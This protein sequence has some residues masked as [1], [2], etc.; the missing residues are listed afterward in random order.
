MMSHMQK[1]VVAAVLVLCGSAVVQGA[2]AA[3]AAR[4]EQT[5]ADPYLIVDCV[6]REV[7]GHIK[8]YRAK[9]TGAEVDEHIDEFF[10]LMDSTLVKAIDF[11]WIALNVMGQYRKTATAEQRR[12]FADAFH[13]GL[14]ETYGRGLLSYSNEKIVLVPASEP[15]GDKRKVSVVQKI[16]GRDA[17][18]PLEYTMGLGKDG[19]WKIINVIIN[20]INLG[21]TFRNQFAQAVQKNSGD[22]NQVI[23][24]WV[25]EPV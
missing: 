11:D 18:H 22:I 20:G 10:A 6:T 21:K 25:P 19:Q 24:G 4:A 1:W 8:A 13:R 15:V 14:V 9:Y 3:E 7:L 12:Q 17:I 16:H 23:V 5:S 2:V